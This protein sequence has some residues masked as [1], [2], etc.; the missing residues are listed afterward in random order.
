MMVLNDFSTGGRLAV[1]GGVVVV[2]VVL[3]E[4]LWR[5]GRRT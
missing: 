5:R 2:I 3:L 4:L 1:Q